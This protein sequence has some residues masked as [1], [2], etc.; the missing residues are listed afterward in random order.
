MYFE[1]YLTPINYKTY[2]KLALNFQAFFLLN[3]K[4]FIKNIFKNLQN[5]KKI[6]FSKSEHFY[7]P[8]CKIQKKKPHTIIKTICSSQN[9]TRINW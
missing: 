7:Y 1:Y 9:L 4:V 6:R 8:K 2:N 3:E 5:S